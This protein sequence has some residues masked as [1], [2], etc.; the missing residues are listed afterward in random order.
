[1][2]IQINYKNKPS[3]KNSINHVIFTDEDFNIL[4]LKK[5]LQKKEYSFVSDLIKS[6]DLK[7]KIINLDVNSKKK[8]TLISLKKI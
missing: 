1:M 7:K 5:Y 4:A 2:N 3:E 8:V 6:K